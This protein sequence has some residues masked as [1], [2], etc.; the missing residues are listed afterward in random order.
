MIDSSFALIFC[1]A[2]V[3][4]LFVIALKLATPAE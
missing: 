2:L 1:F 3:W 4:G